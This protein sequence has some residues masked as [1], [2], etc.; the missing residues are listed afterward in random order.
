MLDGSS[1][2][3]GLVATTPVPRAPIVAT[4]ET[5]S[6][7]LAHHSSDGTA[8]TDR[9]PNATESY[10]PSVQKHIVVVNVDATARSRRAVAVP[11]RQSSTSAPGG[12]TDHTQVGSD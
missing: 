12:S 2:L 6:S 4:C 7:L 1:L 8:T 11:I 10:G 5:R 3:W 9:L